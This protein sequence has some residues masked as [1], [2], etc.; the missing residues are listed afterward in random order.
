MIMRREEYM[1]D[2]NETNLVRQL[3][4][5]DAEQIGNALNIIKNHKT[6]PKV[7]RVSDYCEF[8]NHHLY[9]EHRESVCK[10]YIIDLIKVVENH[11]LAE[12]GEFD[13]HATRLI[14]LY[15]SEEYLKKIEKDFPEM[16][17][18]VKESLVNVKNE[19]G[20]ENH[21]MGYEAALNHLH[22]IAFDIETREES[23]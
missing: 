15:E 7:D 8:I 18:T 23:K 21:T 17:K 20:K 12:N 16:I 1:L 5:K 9:E 10:N 19:I 14:T 6:L 2:K 3:Q 11:G 13:D 22:S 4:S